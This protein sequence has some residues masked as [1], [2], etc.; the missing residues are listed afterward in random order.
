MQSQESIIDSQRAPVLHVGHP[1]AGL[2]A[3]HPGTVTKTE[4]NRQLL[5]FNSMMKFHEINRAE[6]KLMLD[7]TV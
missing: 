4:K 3:G 2:T 5:P 6:M 1:M 7:S